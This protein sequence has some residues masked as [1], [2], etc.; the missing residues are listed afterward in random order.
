MGITKKNQKKSIYDSF[1]DSYTERISDYTKQIEEYRNIKKTEDDKLREEIKRKAIMKYG[2]VDAPQKSPYY[3]PGRKKA[4]PQYIMVNE[5]QYIKEIERFTTDTHYVTLNL[6]RYDYYNAAAITRVVGIEEVEWWEYVLIYGF[7]K[8]LKISYEYEQHKPYLR[9]GVENKKLVNGFKLEIKFIPKQQGKVERKEEKLEDK[10]V[11]K[12]TGTVYE[13]VL[14]N[15]EIP[16]IKESKREVYQKGYFLFEDIY[17]TLVPDYKALNEQ[18]EELLKPYSVH[19]SLIEV[20]KTITK[21]D[22]RLSGV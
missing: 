19:E 1:Y 15:L 12:E 10:I 11:I 20:I 5:V 7:F 2:N 21:E 13:P 6:K 14:L 8:T 9:Q 22:G 16:Q 17:D 18:M 4:P 3:G